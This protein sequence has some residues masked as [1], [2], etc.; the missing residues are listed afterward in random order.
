[1]DIQKHAIKAHIESVSLLER[2]M[3]LYKNDQQL[4][5]GGVG[6]AGLRMLY[7]GRVGPASP[8]NCNDNY[9]HLIVLIMMCTHL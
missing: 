7:F 4:A 8:H 1:M 6:G 2:R 5:L 9:V 3:A